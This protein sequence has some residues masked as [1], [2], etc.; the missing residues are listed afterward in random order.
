VHVFDRF[1]KAMEIGQIRGDEGVV[2]AAG[3]QPLA[4]VQ[5]L[6]D[7]GSVAGSRAARAISSGE[8]ET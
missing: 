7:V 5:P 6:S 1:E 3:G 2:D 4:A 8:P